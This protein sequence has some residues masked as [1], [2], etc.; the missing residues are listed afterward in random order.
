VVDDVGLVGD[1]D[2]DSNQD[3][4][5]HTLTLGAKAFL[6]RRSK[7][8]TVHDGLFGAESACPL[9]GADQAITKL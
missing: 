5:E 4:G 9:P 3:K 1:S 8:T 2:E 6:G 7:K